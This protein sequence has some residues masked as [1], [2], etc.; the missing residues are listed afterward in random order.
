MNIKMRRILAL[1]LALVMACSML[2]ACGGSKKEEAPESGAQKVKVGVINTGTAETMA[3]TRA[4]KEG[5]DY[6][7]EKMP[8][9]EV[10]WVEDVADAGPDCGAMIDTL[11]ADGCDEKAALE[12]V[13]AIING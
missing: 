4:H 7:K 12:A 13:L 6:L 8:D 2:T 3:W 10:I 1:A 5:I 9:V 11:V